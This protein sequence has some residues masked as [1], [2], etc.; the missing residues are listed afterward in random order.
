MKPFNKEQC[1]IPADK[2]KALGHPIR[3]WIALQLLEGEHYVHEFVK[4][5]E[6]DFSTISQHIAALKQ[7]GIIVD[8]KRGKHV[9]YRL[10]CECVK[11]FL[12]CVNDKMNTMRREV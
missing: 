11:V 4:L 8:E 6:L 3:F 1:K 9:F 7:A 5:T 2:F 10:N 12:E